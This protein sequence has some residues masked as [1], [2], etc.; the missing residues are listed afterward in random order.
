MAKNDGFTEKDFNDLIN[1]HG[2]LADKLQCEFR[3]GEKMWLEQIW[4]EYKTGERIGY[5]IPHW[6]SKEEFFSL[7]EEKRRNAI[8]EMCY[9]E[10]EGKVKDAKELSRIHN[11]PYNVPYIKN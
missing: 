8:R 4:K 1:F 7:P 10:L 11:V 9:K 5:A 3:K 6:L 2:R